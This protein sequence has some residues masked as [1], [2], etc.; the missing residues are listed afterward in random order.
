MTTVNVYPQ[1]PATDV[2]AESPL[3]HASLESL[4][5]KGRANPGVFLREKKLLG[6]LTLRGDAHDPAFAAGVHKALGME[7]PAALMLVNAG[8]SSLQWMGPDEWL[9]IVPTGEELAA[10]QKLREALA[11][12]HIA[13]VNVSGGQSILELTGP[14]VRQVLMK[15]TSYDVHPDN[16][17]VGKAVGT[18]FAKSQLVIRRTGEETWELLIRRSFADYWWLWLQD[19]SAEYGLSIQA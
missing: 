8:E 15:S 16:F 12:L 14:K 2:K 7:L 4:V 3:F 17:P 6:H 5:G 9:L 19:A 13:I 11:G 18:V 1:R 10:E